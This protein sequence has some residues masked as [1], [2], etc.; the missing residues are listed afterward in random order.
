MTDIVVP[1]AV[2]ALPVAPDPSTDSVLEFD[3]KA[4]AMVA[5]QKTM[6]AQINDVAAKTRQNA[7]AANERATSADSAKQSAQTAATQAASAAT[8]ASS[9]AATATNKA[10]EA[11]SSADTARQYA[12]SIDPVALK[13]RAN[14]TGTQAIST[15]SGLQAALDSKE[16]PAGAL[17]QMQAF[18]LGRNTGP[19]VTDLDGL[20]ASGF[21][22]ASSVVSAAAGLPLN[23]LGHTIIHSAGST[24][25]AQQFASPT[26]TG[27]GNRRR[28]WHRQMIADGWSAWRELAFLDDPAFTGTPSA[29]SLKLGNVASTDVNTLDYYEEGTF[30]PALYGVT[31]AG[32]PSY[33]AR[34]GRYT[35]IGNRV[36]WTMRLALSAVGGM[37]GALRLSGLPFIN[38]NVSGGDSSINFG[39]YAGIQAG[40][41][42]VGVSGLTRVNASEANLYK[43]SAANRNVAALQASEI[44]DAFTIYA[45]GVYEV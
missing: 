38:A 30:T 37:A 36:S 29:P 34:F 8:Q 33:S 41:D 10:S 39:Y 23:T 43:A 15:V 24:G 16:T 14:H 12:Q 9:A 13:D 27:V 18:G 40:V 45:S 26:T 3:A 25:A 4:N 19:L 28:L 2:D 22:S 11:S 5:A 32:S 21:Y 17:A 6:V 1:G 20:R 31:T 42:V 7:I 35:R 44:T